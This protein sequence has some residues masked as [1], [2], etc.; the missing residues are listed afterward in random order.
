MSVV[1]QPGLVEAVE[2]ALHVLRPLERKLRSYGLDGLHWHETHE[3]FECGAGLVDP[4]HLTIC[5]CKQPEA[6]RGIG[7]SCI[8]ALPPEEGAGKL[9]RS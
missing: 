6:G 7:G 2:E 8:S 9:W 3:L 5:C 4:A 1:G